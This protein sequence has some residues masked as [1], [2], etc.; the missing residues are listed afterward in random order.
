MQSFKNVV[1]RGVG[2]ELEKIESKWKISEMRKNLDLLTNERENSKKELGENMSELKKS[3]KDIM[4]EEKLSKQMKLETSLHYLKEK[5]FG[6]K[7]LK[8]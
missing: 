3:F 1:H 4:E 5:K 2:K 7:W 8:N 6:W